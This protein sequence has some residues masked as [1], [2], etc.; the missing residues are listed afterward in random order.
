MTQLYLFNKNKLEPAWS[1]MQ[2]DVF[3]PFGWMINEY[4]QGCYIHT[5]YPLYVNGDVENLP[6]V[7][8][9]KNQHMPS[10]YLH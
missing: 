7:C 9:S 8:S 6:R 4:R 5:Q 10:I 2:F 3:D 1:S